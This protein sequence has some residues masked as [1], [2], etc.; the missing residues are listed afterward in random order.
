[1]IMFAHTRRLAAL[2]MA[3][4]AHGAQA[5]TDLL[6]A[7]QAAQQHDATYAAARAQWQ[8]GATRER[9]ARALLRPQVSVSGSAGYGVVDRDTRGAQFSAPG[10]GAA[11]DASFRTRVDGGTS[12]AW[13]VIARQPIYSVERTASAHQLERQAQLA[14][15]Q[16]RAAEQALILRTAA[17]Y[18]GVILAE[19][20]LATLRAQKAE[21]E[22][23]LEAAR[24]KFEAGATPVTD[25]DEAQAR[26]DDIRT[27]EIVAANEV[28]LKR[29]LYADITGLP[30]QGLSRVGAAPPGDRRATRAM[31]EATA[32][33]GRNNPLIAMQALGV[34]IARDELARYRALV[35]PEVDLFARLADERMHGPSGY[36]PR[37]H[38][39]SNARIVGLQV[40]IPLYTGGMRSAKRDEAA[41]LADKAQHESQS[42]RED[43]LRQAQAAWLAVST[44]AER[45]LA[46]EQALKSARSRLGATETGKEVGART[47]LDFMNAQSDYF[48]AQRNL[49]QARYELLLDRLRLAAVTGELGEAELRDVNADLTLR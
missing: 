1:M 41:A 22:R 23:A 17:A 29:Q 13:A 31:D 39:T 35:S 33:A 18:F 34:D 25:R 8:A 42:L 21:A 36:G 46:H 11:N 12:T 48:Q 27:R 16:L 19:E 45:V 28:T 38:V 44:G 14:D 6:G 30:A 7:W 10:F 3:V 37:S 40:T 5:G 43:V 24:E 49:L 32:L 15:V 2:A 47:M 26:Y 4:L 9:Q 20:T